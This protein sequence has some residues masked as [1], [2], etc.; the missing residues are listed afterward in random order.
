MLEIMIWK[1]YGDIVW[2]P[3][4]KKKFETLTCK[5][6]VDMKKNMFEREK[7]NVKLLE[8]THHITPLGQTVCNL[9]SK[10]PIGPGTIVVP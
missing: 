7:R 10:C 6:K 2:T 4:G 9:M 1:L 5:C 8:N 3:W